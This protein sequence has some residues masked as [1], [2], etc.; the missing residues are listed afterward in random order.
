MESGA[1]QKGD[2]LDANRGKEEEDVQR[3]LLAEVPTGRKVRVWGPASGGRGLGKEEWGG[4]AG[5]RWG[6]VATPTA[7]N[8]VARVELCGQAL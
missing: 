8:V 1:Q 2:K 7:L 3:G 4:D 6:A 5:S